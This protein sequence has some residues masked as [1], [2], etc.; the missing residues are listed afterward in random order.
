MQSPPRVVNWGLPGDDWVTPAQPNDMPPPAATSAADAVRRPRGLRVFRTHRWTFEVALFAVGLLI[1]QV[2][3]A[4]VIG[5]PTDA[6]RNS[7]EIIGLEKTYGIFVEN[8]VQSWLVDNLH[9][10]QFLNHFYV[11]AHL[12]VTALFFVW[13]YRRRRDVYPFVRNAFF[14]ANGIALAVFVVYPVAPPRL[15]TQEGFVD[16]LSIISGIDLHAGH[17]S[18]WF[19]PFAAVPS[20]HF[21]YALM[22]G[23]VCAV[24]VRSVI[25]KALALTYPVLV[26]ITI[27]GTANHYVLD[28]LAGAAVVVSGFAITAVWRSVRGHRAR[29][30]A[31]ALDSTC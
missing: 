9:V 3:R 31:Q 4:V 16:T 12:P 22:I 24:L 6:F 25:V 1:Y 29:P 7:L 15:V 2:S 5:D 14:V 11:W 26:F 21:A 23:V 20:M 27:V 19:N 18:G 10:M 30:P 13:L 28:A 17:L 8:S